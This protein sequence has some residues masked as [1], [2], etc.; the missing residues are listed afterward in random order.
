[1]E[2]ENCGSKHDGS[3]GAGRFCCE[4]CARSFSTKSNRA[5][6][7]EKTRQTLLKK[8][9]NWKARSPRG[10]ETHCLYCGK[11]LSGRPHTFCD[12]VCQQT[13]NYLIYINRWKLG[14]ENGIRSKINVSWHIRKYLFEKHNN[15]CSK[16]GWAEVNPVTG[17]VPLQIHYIDGDC[18]NNVESNLELLCPNCHSITP[19]Y[20]SLNPVSK[21]VYRR[22]PKRLG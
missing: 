18:T 3:Y 11:K 21:R 15:R 4:K 1:M 5:E 2:C 16:C 22:R 8:N 17:N 12:N 10:K 6:I 13:Y 20:G 14:L 9:P 19:N 7:S